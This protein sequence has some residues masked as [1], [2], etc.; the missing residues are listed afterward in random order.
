MT[1]T[2][3]GEGVDRLGGLTGI[4]L[5]RRT[6]E[7]ARA[8]ARAQGKDAGRGRSAPAV[9]RRAG[10]Q[11]RSWSG[12]GPDGRDPQPL[13][14]L[15]RD[16]AKKRGWA[17]HV[18]EGTVLGHWASVV[19]HQIADHATPTALSEGVLS[20]TAESTAWAT[21]LRMIQAQLLAKIA[22]AVGNGVVTSLK[23]TGPAA[24]SWRKG[25]RHIAGR[26]PRDTY[27]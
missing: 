22:A 12:P 21:Q 3:D 16:L 27:G 2:G 11:R 15:A 24:P 6:L 17:T 25:P 26:G 4:D 23:I 19:G 18:A 9:P 7:E 8:A 5:V 20:V 1:G 13:G 14:R 10:G